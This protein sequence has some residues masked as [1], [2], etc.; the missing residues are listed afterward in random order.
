MSSF[1]VRALVL[2]LYPLTVSGGSGYNGAVLRT[3]TALSDLWRRY[4]LAFVPAL[5]PGGEDMMKWI[6]ERE[7]RAVSVAGTYRVFPHW[8]MPGSYIA[9]LSWFDMKGR[10]FEHTV[11]VFPTV[12]AAKAACERDTKDG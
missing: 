2:V 7:Y 10:L 5:L 12:A 4:G 9:C 11:G 6:E 3:R 8:G 1:L